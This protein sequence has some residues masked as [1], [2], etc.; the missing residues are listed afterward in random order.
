MRPLFD[1]KRD[2]GSVG[3]FEIVQENRCAS[4]LMGM[5]H[6][7]HMGSVSSIETGEARRSDHELYSSPRLCPTQRCKQ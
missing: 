1:P 4:K 5:S 2:Q 3:G 7:V 6:R